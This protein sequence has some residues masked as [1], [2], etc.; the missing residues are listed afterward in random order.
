MKVS[1]GKVQGL[2]RKYET[3]I[4]NLYIPCGNKR[5]YVLKQTCN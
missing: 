5:S 2:I 4:L 1:N 3:E